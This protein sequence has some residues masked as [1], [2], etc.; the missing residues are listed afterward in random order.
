MN[1]PVSLRRTLIVPLIALCVIC[2]VS[3]CRKHRGSTNLATNVQHV[4]NSP[5]LAILKWSN[6]SDYQ[7]PVKQF[8]DA[9]DYALAWTDDGKLTPQANTFIQA[10]ANAGLKGL[11]PD[12]YDA[13]RWQQRVA[14][15]NSIDKSHDTSDTAQDTV[16]QFDAAMTISAMRY[17]SDLHSGRVNPQHLNFD[18]DVPAKRAA[19]DLAKFL[20]DQVVEA[21]DVQ[22]AIASVEPQNPMY[23]ATE[24]AL[25][26]YIALARQ[27]DAKSPA[28]SM[29]VD[30]LVGA[31]LSAV[32]KPISVDQPYPAASLYKLAVRLAFEGDMPNA[33]AGQSTVGTVYTQEFADAVQHYQQRHGLTP[34]GKLSQATIASL[35]VPMDVRVQQLSLSL[36]RWRWLDE[37]YTNPRLLENLAEFVVRAYEP[38]HTLAFKMKTVNGQAKGEHDTPVFTRTMKFLVFRP[39][40]N[41]PPSIIKKELTPHIEKSGVGYL[42]QKN[43]EVTKADGSIVTGYSASDIEHLRY[44]V[45]EKPGPKN[46][47]GLVK[48]MFPNEYDV[49]MHSTPELNL[50]NLTRRDRSH[51]CV[52]LEHADQMAAWVL[53]GQ[54]DWDSDKI[55]EAMK[56]EDKNNKTVSLKTQLP[57]VIFYLTA[58][59]DEDGTTHFFD[60]IYGYDKQLEDILNKGMPY[61]SSPAKV[62]PKLTPGETV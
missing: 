38:D 59:A 54:G 50:F 13:A 39:Y 27:Q 52:R 31:A 44:A 53:Q 25:Q 40:W 61:P 17:L 55:S 18:I 56:D 20:N 19:F 5:R 6:F 14:R 36:E 21:D 7:E 42:A 34:D 11:R 22:S 49:Y 4:I 60:D 8:Y 43:F 46:S 58:T 24:Q 2:F 16:A 47:L 29:G 48:F 37:P 28:D 30:N 51:G 33:P 10:F 57:V 41:V 32:P 23:A 62:N 12:D 1:S 26:Q 15:I 35:N 45:R 3:G 9:R